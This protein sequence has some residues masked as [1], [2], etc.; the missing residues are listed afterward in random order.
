MDWYFICTCQTRAPNPKPK[1]KGRGEEIQKNGSKTRQQEEGKI[2]TLEV[3]T[4][5]SSSRHP[6][7]QILGREPE[8]NT[9]VMRIEGRRRSSSDCWP[10][11]H[12]QPASQPTSLSLSLDFWAGVN[13]KVAS[14]RLP[15]KT[16]NDFLNERSITVRERGSC[17]H[18]DSWRWN[19]FG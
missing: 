1:L 6:H 10:W 19:E 13:T 16:R 14:L 2:Q 17:F 5:T 3:K 11:C 12:S 18:D 15:N 7:F 4:P 8:P 9:T